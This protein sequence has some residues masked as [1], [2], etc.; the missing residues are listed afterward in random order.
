[1]DA[2]QHQRKLKICVLLASYEESTSDMKG[3]DPDKG[4][5]L[6][7]AAAVQSAINRTVPML[8]AHHCAFDDRNPSQLSSVPA[9]AVPAVYDTAGKYE[10]STVPIHKA[11]A[12]QQIL[13]LSRQGYDLF[14][15]LC[16]GAFD[17]DRAGKEV[18]EALER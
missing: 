18:V 15:N 10:W 2:E 3:L 11:R 8:T 12:V 9:F 4:G 13:A 6:S 7:K 1:M 14:M 5:L 16:D 17:E